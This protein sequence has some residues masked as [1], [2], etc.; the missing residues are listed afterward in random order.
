[1]SPW[2]VLAR[3]AVIAFL[4]LGA[5][6]W[7]S[8]RPVVRPRASRILRVAVLVSAAM[9][10]EYGL[11]QLPAHLESAR[12]EGTLGLHHYYGM[13]AAWIFVA[14]QLV[15][16]H[17]IGRGDPRY[18]GWLAPAIVYLFAI[19]LFGGLGFGAPLML[20]ADSGRAV[21]LAALAVAHHRAAP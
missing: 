10:I 1:M 6:R 17:W 4:L 18:L 19:G 13:T 8:G 5:A 12:A 7:L 21:L 11:F 2:L 3:V 15:A 9:G 16:A 14:S 20:A